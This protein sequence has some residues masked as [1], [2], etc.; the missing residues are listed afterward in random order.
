MGAPTSA[1][2]LTGICDILVGTAGSTANT[3]LGFTQDGVELA[4]DTTYERIMMDQGK[5]PVKILAT[6]HSEKVRLNLGEATMANLAR[7]FHGV[8]TSTNTVI[9]G[10]AADS[11]VSL[12]IIGL[13]PAGTYRVWTIPYCQSVGNVVYRY[14]KGGAQVLAVEFE[15]LGKSGSNPITITDVN[16]LSVTI[17]SG[18]FART[19]NRILH[20]VKGEGSA[21]DTLTD[22]SGTLSDGEIVILRPYAASQAITVTHEADTISL[23]GSANLTLTQPTDTLVLAYATSGTKWV[24][25]SRWLG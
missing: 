7:S 21:A 23:T 14:S 5:R 17:S 24:E 16:D 25:Q 13:D 3:L 10:S 15:V 2:V 8:S 20:I 12:M 19:A 9:I 18:T 4:Q 6:E 11:E 1:N 22:I